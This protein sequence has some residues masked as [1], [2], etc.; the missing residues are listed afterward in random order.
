MKRKGKSKRLTPRAKGGE[1]LA[2]PV[3]AERQDEGWGKG[4]HDW[5]ASRG[6]FGRALLRGSKSGICHCFTEA[7]GPICL[8]IPSPYNGDNKSIHFT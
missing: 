8:T 3:G 4:H 1:R 5:Q 7:N 2:V 6:D